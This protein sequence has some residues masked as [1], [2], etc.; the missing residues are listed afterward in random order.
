MTRKMFP[1]AL[2]LALASAVLADD[3]APAPPVVNPVYTP[4]IPA[5]APASTHS[6]SEAD[7]T[8]IV[9]RAVTRAMDQQRATTSPQ[10]AATLPPSAA[11]QTVAAPQQVHV[12]VYPGPLARGLSRVGE[13]LVRL[14]D[15]KVR[16]MT[17][18]TTQ[19]TLTTSPS[20]APSAAATL[21][22]PAASAQ[23]PLAPLASMQAR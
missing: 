20:V 12:L 11:V 13:K 6:L 14:G 19:T 1:V 5:I 23:W 4:A 10:Q 3:K 21:F 15:P 18:S 22:N 9:D 16:P 17:I 2:V 8:A 7:I